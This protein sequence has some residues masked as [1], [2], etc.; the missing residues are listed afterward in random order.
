MI[1][2]PFDDF[3]STVGQVGLFRDSGDTTAFAYLLWG[4]GVRF[5]DEAAVDG[6]RKVHA[7]GKTG[8]VDAGA[9]G[10]SSLLEC[11]FIDVGQGD[12]VLIKTPDF[13]HLLIDGGFPRKKQPCGK[14]AADFV[15]W[16][17][18]KDYGL[19]TIALDAL[20][21]SH[22][23]E[24]HYGGLSDLLDAAQS[25]E[26]D[27]R[28]VTVEAFFHAGVSWWKDA[29][30][31]RTLGRREAVAGTPHLVDL[32][33]DRNSALI[34]LD[35]QSARPLQG[36]WA[37]FLRRVADARRSDGEF[38][39]FTRLSDE[40]PYLPGFGPDEGDVEI[41][42]LAPIE[43]DVGGV[44]GLQSL[45]ADSKN[46]N[47]HSVMLRVDFGRTRTL[48]TGDLNKAAQQRIL[49]EMVGSRLDLQCDVAKACHHGSSDVSMAFLQAMSPSTTIISSGDAEG[50][51]HPRPSI[52]AAS[53]VTGNLTIRDDEILTPLVYSTELAR[54]YALGRLTSVVQPDGTKLGD[55]AA[56]RATTLNYNV[57]KAGDLRPKKD[58]RKAAGAY[59]V[60]GLVYGLV[61][62][63]TDG[64]MILAATMDEKS[65][66]WSIRTFPARF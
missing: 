15:D 27:A 5:V 31:E 53:G 30:G 6:R 11:Y 21:S 9:L 36:E 20:I 40:I 37:A 39:P 57:T 63:R 16:K 32:L 3:V 54:S 38:T 13:R 58:S 33:E 8:W 7:R 1:A 45:G 26:L 56:L 59:V 61:N 34:G 28:A 64:Q 19:R 66:N 42:V 44:P 49:N 4:D 43:Q 14:S 29:A 17:F 51:D 46:T 47:G 18:A 23:D 41:R 12:G 2:S 24:D 55:A 52:V 48:L 62:I 50:H 65:T 35:A 25:D 60:A 10:G 22:N